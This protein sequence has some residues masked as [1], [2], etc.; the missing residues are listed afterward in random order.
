MKAQLGYSCTALL[1]CK[2]GGGW[3]WEV[4]A[5]FR[6]FYLLE[7]EPVLIVQEVRWVPGPVLK[8]AENFAVSGI[9]SPDRTALR[10]SLS[11]L[12]HSGPT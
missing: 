8:V 11:R 6:P 10:E 7:R 2:L 4:N 1:F 12:R 9:R 3:E 5:T